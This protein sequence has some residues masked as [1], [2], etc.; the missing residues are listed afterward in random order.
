MEGTI[1]GISLMGSIADRAGASTNAKL[2][3]NNCYYLNSSKNSISF[4]DLPKYYGKGN[5]G[6]NSLS[7]LLRTEAARGKMLNGD[8]SYLRNYGWN[9]GS[10][11]YSIKG[12][13]GAP[14]PTSSPRTTAPA[15]HSATIASPP[16]WAAALRGSLPRKTVP[17]S[18]ANTASP[19]A[20]RP[21]RVR[22]SPSP[23]CW[24]RITSLAGPVYTTAGGR[25]LAS[26]GARAC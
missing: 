5:S 21:C 25:H 15:L 16:L 4:D 8:L 2:Y 14:V 26:T 17:R 19:A 13:A 18:T 12:L 7:G 22:T 10:N 24:S 20:T 3:I 11:T 23:P 6:S 1:T 9:G